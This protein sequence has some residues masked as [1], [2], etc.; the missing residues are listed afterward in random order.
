MT[1]HTPIQAAR[2]ITADHAVPAGLPVLA[3]PRLAQ[4]LGEELLIASRM[5]ADLAYELGSDPNTLRKHMTS[6]QHIDHITQIQ[7]NIAHLLQNQHH[8]PIQHITLNDMADRVR[9]AVEAPHA[10]SG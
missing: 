2:P 7:L 9:L 4:A 3:D 5:L 6:L 8:N 1:A 10:A